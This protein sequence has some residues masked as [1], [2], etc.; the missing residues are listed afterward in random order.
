MASKRA[1]INIGSKDLVVLNPNL[2]DK[3]SSILSK[4]KYTVSRGNEFLRPYLSMHNLEF[5][6]NLAEFSLEERQ[7]ILKIRKDIVLYTETP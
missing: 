7:Y 2:P 1:T 5:F 4:S 6:Y 3:A